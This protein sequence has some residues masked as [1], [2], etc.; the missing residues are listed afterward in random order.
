M[1]LGLTK[2]FLMPMFSGVRFDYPRIVHS[3]ERN[4]REN[5]KIEAGYGFQKNKEDDPLV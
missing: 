1:N 5:R 2:T 4:V 3:D